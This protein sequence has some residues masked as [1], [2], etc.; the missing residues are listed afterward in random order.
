MLMSK[1]LFRFLVAAWL[2]LA[3]LALLQVFLFLPK[4]APGR[5]VPIFQLKGMI[6]TFL[7][8]L[9]VH[10]LI[11]HEQWVVRPRAG[12]SRTISVT[13]FWLSVPCASFVFVAFLWNFLLRGW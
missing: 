6:A 13:L 8:F 9:V 10:M 2:G 5:S 3:T 4:S 12:L 11:L 1:R 7:A